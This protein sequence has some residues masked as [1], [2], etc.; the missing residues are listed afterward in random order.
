MPSPS[1]K[2]QGFTIRVNDRIA[3]LLEREGAKYNLTPR[4]AAREL[5][6]VIAEDNLIEAVLGDEYGAPK[7]GVRP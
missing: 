7:D 3:R 4:L 1:Q 6:R 2:R 5:L